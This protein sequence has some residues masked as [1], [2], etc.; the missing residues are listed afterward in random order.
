MKK[1]GTEMKPSNSQQNDV[2]I[3]HKKESVK[4]DIVEDKDTNPEL[5]ISYDGLG[6]HSKLETFPVSSKTLSMWK[7]K[8]SVPKLTAKHKLKR[9]ELAGNQNIAKMLEKIREK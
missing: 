8:S 2:S 4:M 7:P 9:P 6:G 1:L 3:F 5:N